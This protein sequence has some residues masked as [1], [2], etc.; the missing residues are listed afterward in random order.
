MAP[1]KQFEPTVVR[2]H[3][4][5]GHQFLFLWL[6]KPGLADRCN[7]S[8]GEGFSRLMLPMQCFKTNLFRRIHLHSPRS[9]TRP[10]VHRKRCSLWRKV[11]HGNDSP[12]AS[13][14]GTIALNPAPKSGQTSCCRIEI[15]APRSVL[16]CV[17]EVSKV[18]RC[19]QT[20]KSTT[21]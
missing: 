6:N 3:G 16:A 9:H 17:P 7:Q 2:R 19:E 5:A 13:R 10:W 4:R 21:N 8:L 18:H 14:L 15:V 1:K 20:L 12:V 11:L